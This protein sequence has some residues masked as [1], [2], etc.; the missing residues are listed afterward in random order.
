M[1]TKGSFSRDEWNN[2]LHLFNNSHFSSTCCAENS[3]LISCPKTMAKRMQ[4]QK[5]EERCVAKSKST[6]TNSASYVPTSSSSAKSPIASKGP[7]IRIPT[8]KPE[9]RMRGNSE[10]DAASSS[11]A[12]L[13]DAYF[14]GLMD[15]ATGKPVAT[16]EESGDVDLSESQT[17]NEDITGK[18]VACETAAGKPYAPSQSACQGRP[19]AEK[20]EWSH[21]LRVSPAANHHLETVLKGIYGREHDDPMNDW[22]A[23]MA[24]WGIFLKA[25]LRAAVHL[26]QD[27]ETN[28]HYAKSHVWDSLGQLFGELKRLICEQS[29]IFGQKNTRDRW[30]EN[31]GIRRNY[32]EIGKLIV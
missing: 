30:F 28:L 18:R 9:S 14:G 5:G 15:T 4:E 29:E 27:Y 1:L 25:T 10:S 12:R 16:K 32:M 23:N 11:Q 20:T 8:E 22:D 26:G 2:L 21:N 19:K 17:G 31:N 6:A 24:I 3:S 7:G 13:K